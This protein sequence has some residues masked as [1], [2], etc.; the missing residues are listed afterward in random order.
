MTVNVNTNVAVPVYWES[1]NKL[2][3][4]EKINLIVLLSSSLHKSKSEH[5]DTKKWASKYAGKWQDSRS[6]DDIVS[7]IR[8]AR[9]H[10]AFDYSL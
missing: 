9:T 8:G 3:D 10:N 2:S 1:L 4:T 6:A 7:E 5:K